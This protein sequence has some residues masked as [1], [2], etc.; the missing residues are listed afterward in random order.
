LLT[1]FPEKFIPILNAEDQIKKKLQYLV[2]NIEMTASG[3]RAGGAEVGYHNGREHAAPTTLHNHHTK[4]LTLRLR[5]HHLAKNGRILE[6]FAPTASKISPNC[7]PQRVGS[8]LSQPLSTITT[9][10]IYLT[11][12]LRHHHLVKIENLRAVCPN[13]Q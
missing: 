2:A 8:M 13:C 11:L 1:P 5:H 4:D 9:P 10:R 12:C 7:F 3:G 6:L